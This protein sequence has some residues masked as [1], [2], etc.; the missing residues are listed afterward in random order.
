MR[1]SSSRRSSVVW[2]LGIVGRPP[3]RVSGYGRTFTALQHRS[4][5]QACSFRQASQASECFP[6]WDAGD[7]LLVQTQYEKIAVDKAFA[8]ADF[9]RNGGAGLFVVL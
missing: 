6:A 3:P 9:G 4:N 7:F 1:A 8:S 5:R 2:I